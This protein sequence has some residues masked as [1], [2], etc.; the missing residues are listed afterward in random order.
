MP[1]EM[2]NIIVVDDNQVLLS[3]IVEIFKECGYTVRT[4]TDGFAALA[5]IRRKVPHVLRSDLDMQ[6]MSGF[7]L[8]SVV[9][10]R[11]PEIVAIAMSGA[12]PGADVVRAIAADAFYAKGA[13]KVA[14]LCEIVRAMETGRE[15]YAARAKT[16]IW[17]QGLPIDRSDTSTVI[18]PC[19]ECLRTFPHRLPPANLFQDE[20]CCP[21][22]FEPVQL[23]IVRQSREP[24]KTLFPTLEWRSK[25]ENLQR[26]CDDSQTIRLGNY[27]N[28]D[29]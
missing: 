2:T 23:A 24:D 26:E 20:K 12:Y 17:V 11:F 5:K 15:V 6:G 22:C 18:V 27:I 21:H 1:S 14:Q 19:P 3:V 13:S 25:G 28:H 29:Q 9:R 7:E 4:A 16:P 10:R 8:L